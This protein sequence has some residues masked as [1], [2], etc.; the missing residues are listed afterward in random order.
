MTTFLYHGLTVTSLQIEFSSKFLNTESSKCYF[1][2]MK[3]LVNKETESIKG[4]CRYGFGGGTC[5][6]QAGKHDKRCA[7]THS[8]PVAYRKI[9]INSWFTHPYWKANKW[10]KNDI[11]ERDKRGTTRLKGMHGCPPKK[12][13]VPDFT[14]ACDSKLCCQPAP[15]WS[16]FNLNVSSPFFSKIK[17][18]AF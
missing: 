6:N 16:I 5:H 1:E 12:T 3:R 2:R 8:F 13:T 14:P 10:Q 4:F 18:T 9:S 11:Q 15:P 17:K 7:H